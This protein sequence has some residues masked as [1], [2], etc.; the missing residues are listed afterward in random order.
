MSSTQ[1]QR[2]KYQQNVIRNYYKNQ[3]G[4]LMQRLQETVTNLYLSE[5][6]A[7]TKHWQT[8]ATSLEKLGVPR[9]RID[10]LIKSNQPELLANLV[11]ELLAKSS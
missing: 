5:G 2:T 8:A 1:P 4:I 7:R 10:H 3:D 6:K 11:S 9:S